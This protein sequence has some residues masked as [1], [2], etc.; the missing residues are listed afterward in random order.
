[1]DRRPRLVGHEMRIGLIG[2]GH[3]PPKGSTTTRRHAGTLHR[4]LNRIGQHDL[5]LE[6]PAPDI[7]LHILRFVDSNRQLV[8]R[9]LAQSMDTGTVR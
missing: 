4:R 1:M 3:H 6:H 2:R 9:F 8:L 7:F 5:S